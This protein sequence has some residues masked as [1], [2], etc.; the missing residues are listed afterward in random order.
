MAQHLPQDDYDTQP[1]HLAE[2][3]PNYD[4]VVD[5]DDV[6]EDIHLASV[7]EKKR[8]WWR[9]ALINMMF[10]ASW[11][12]VTRCKQSRMLIKGYTLYVP[13][14]LV[15]RFVF[16]MILSVYNKWM[17]DPEYFGFPFP[18]FVTMMHMFVQFLIAAFLRNVFPRVFRPEFSPGRDDYA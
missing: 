7:E 4:D 8:R 6:H 5:T 14:N 2:Q 3:P 9:N 10:I 15:S 11:C 1:P 18:L 16:A 12:V 13:L 17:F